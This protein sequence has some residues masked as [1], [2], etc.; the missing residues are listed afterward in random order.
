MPFKKLIQPLQ[1]KLAEKGF[2]EPLDFQKKVLS[3]IK[4]GANMYAIA[5]QG[6]G[7][8]TSLVLSVLQKLN[9]EAFQEA[10]RAL[11][12]VQDRKAAQDLERQFK[13]FKHRELR[14]YSVYEEKDFDDQRD[15]IYDGVDV[16]IA[17][18]KRLTKIFLSNGINLNRLQMMIVDDAEFLIG[19]IG[20]SQVSRIPESLSKCQYLIFAENYNN[21]FNQWN[22]TFMFN[23]QLI[24]A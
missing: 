23:A 22:D 5:P 17:T 18:P 14:V 24:K 15:D 8:T 13:E 12:F 11:I 1:D 10:P 4:G 9:N 21:R 2:D 16:V 20:L 19:N 3:K 7:K 6:A